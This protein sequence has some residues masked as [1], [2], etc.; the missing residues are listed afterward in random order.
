MSDQIIHITYKIKEL[1]YEFFKDFSAVKCYDSIRP[2][3]IAGDKQVHDI[4]ALKYVPTN[5]FFKTDFDDDWEELPQ[6]PKEN[7]GTIKALYRSRRKIKKSKFLHLQ[8]L[9]HVM[10]HLYHE[11][12]DNLPHDGNSNAEND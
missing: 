9:K 10:P 8:Q 1:N 3:R 6:R 2:G 12:Y 11:F 7:K 4:R 5:I